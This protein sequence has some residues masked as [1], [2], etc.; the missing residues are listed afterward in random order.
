MNVGQRIVLG[1]LRLYRVV[2]SPAWAALARPWGLGCRFVPTCSQYA[3]E[4]VRRFGVWRGL[5][6]ALR[7]LGRCHPW[8]PWGYDPVPDR[9]EPAL[10]KGS[11]PAAARP[12][13]ALVGRGGGRS[14][15]G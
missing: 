5:V 8:G 14:A 11:G 12:R 4:A 3:A 13:R 9:P 10:G 7:R 6:L 1:L 2:I 15:G